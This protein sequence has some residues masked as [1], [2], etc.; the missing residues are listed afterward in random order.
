MTMQSTMKMHDIPYRHE[1]PRIDAVWDKP[2]WQ[3]VAALETVHVHWPVQSE[4]RPPTRVKLQYDAEN[5]YVIFQVYDRYVRAAAGQT[6]GEVWKDSCV[7][8]F[9]APN[10]ARPHAYFNLE[11][12]CRGVLL[13]QHHTGPRQN[14]RF[15]AVEDC[16]KIR[17]A[18]SITEPFEGQINEPLEWTLEYA[19]PF[20]ILST[21]MEI[22][23]PAPGVCW[24]ANFYK[25]ADECSHPHWLSWSPLDIPEPDFH[26]PEFFGQMR[27]MY[28]LQGRNS[29]QSHV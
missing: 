2:F 26:R 3:K 29:W 22:D 12:N 23:R 17:L 8:F 19:L 15:L 16:E 24:R 27:F 13:A 6:H 20:G 7:E 9:F 25:C 21:Y 10:S 18:A 5:L 14:S 28:T 11:A 1:P 4:H